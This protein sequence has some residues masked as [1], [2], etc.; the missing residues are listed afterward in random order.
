MDLGGP[1]LIGLAWLVLNAIRKAGSIPP[2][3]KTPP[4]RP[5]AWHQGAATAGRP[6]TP[7][8]LEFTLSAAVAPSARHPRSDPGGRR[9]AR[10]APAPAWPDV[11][12]AAGP[13]GRAP[14]RVL[15]SAEETEEGASLEVAPEVRSLET[16]TARPGRAVVDQ[17]DEAEAVIAR[18]LQAAEEHAAPRTRADYQ[19]FDAR[20]RQEAADKTTAAGSRAR[21][22]WEAVVWREILGPPV[23]LRGEGDPER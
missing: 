16:G 18:R 10:A 15:P 12:G 13:A 21:R 6:W 9:Q 3:S 14:D 23:S 20:I 17:D 11:G 4:Q 1:I 22:L 2:T 19:A 8:N 5:P 7:R